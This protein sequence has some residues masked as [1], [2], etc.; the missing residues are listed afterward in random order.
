VA[1]ALP[2]AVG[3]IKGKADLHYNFLGQAR[4]FE[5]FTSSGVNVSAGRASRNI[6]TFSNIGELR[7]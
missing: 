5:P 7:V 2:G 3:G 1:L 4:P 6:R